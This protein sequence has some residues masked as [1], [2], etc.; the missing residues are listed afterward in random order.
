MRVQSGGRREAGSRRARRGRT[1][2]AAHPAVADAFAPTGAHDLY[3]A[4]WVRDLAHLYRFLTQ[5]LGGPGVE[6]AG[7]VIVGQ[8]VKRPGRPSGPRP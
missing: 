4:V 3:I 6:G 8:A 7:T 5:D 2:A 1:G